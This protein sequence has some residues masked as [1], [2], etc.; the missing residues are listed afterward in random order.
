MRPRGDEGSG[1]PGT[2]SPPAA[3]TTRSCSGHPN[4]R[5]GPRTHGSGRGPG[6]AW[7]EGDEPVGDTFPKRL[8]RALRGGASIPGSVRRRGR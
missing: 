6:A 5:G 8:P 7:R 4:W 1:R 2:E 3:S